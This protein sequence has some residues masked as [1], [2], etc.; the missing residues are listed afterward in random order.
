MAQDS[1]NVI[2]VLTDSG[3][4]IHAEVQ[5]Y[6]VSQ[7]QVRE[8]ADSAVAQEVVLADHVTE[9]VGNRVVDVM[10]K[11]IYRAESVEVPE[12]ILRHLLNRI[13]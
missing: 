1:S 7:V 4:V 5:D 2:L 6:W 13:S 3:I 9:K 11:V 8:Y 12:N 10:A